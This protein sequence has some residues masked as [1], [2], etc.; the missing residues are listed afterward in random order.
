MASF[1]VDRA[2]YQGKTQGKFCFWGYF[3]I[4]ELAPRNQERTGI[5]SIIGQSKVE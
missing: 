5:R 3:W 1:L 2:F 4:T